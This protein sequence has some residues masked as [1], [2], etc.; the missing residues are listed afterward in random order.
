MLPLTA[1]TEGILNIDLFRKLPKGA[2]I[3][4]VA[5]GQHLVDG[6]LLEALNSGHIAGATLD[7]FHEEPLPSDHLFWEHPDILVTPHIASLI[8]PVA[9]GER[10]AE[11]IR[12][13]NAGEHVTD[14]V[15]LGSEY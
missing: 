1:E 2:Q 3:I 15:P 7:V 11:N 9:G 5:R 13:F 8:D 10:I 12:A 4:N 14:M 6:D